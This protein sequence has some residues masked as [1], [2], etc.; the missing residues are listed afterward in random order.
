MKSEKTQLNRSKTKM[1]LVLSQSEIPNAR[2]GVFTELPIKCGSFLGSYRGRKYTPD[3]YASLVESGKLLSGYGFDVDS[4]RESI[5]VDAS[6]LERSNWT[7]Y[8][9]CARNF[10]EENVY[11]KDED[12]KINFYALRDIEPGEELLFYYGDA[13]AEM[14]GINYMSPLY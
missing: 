7:R 8:M 9:N 11:F 14:L 5:V 2:T 13:Y 10:N 3:D 6:D 4:G 12:G 1:R